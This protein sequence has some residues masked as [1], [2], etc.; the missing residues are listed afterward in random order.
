M[1]FTDM[2]AIPLICF[3]YASMLRQHATGAPKA[4]ASSLIF[5]CQVDQRVDP[6][7]KTTCVEYCTVVPLAFVPTSTVRVRPKYHLC[8]MAIWVPGSSEMR[9]RGSLAIVH[10][11]KLFA[12]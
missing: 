2:S 8:V 5:D 7:R 12:V 1:T 11:C 9:C 3:V 4:A 6:L 10:C